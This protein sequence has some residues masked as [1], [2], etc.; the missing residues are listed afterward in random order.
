MMDNL[1]KRTQMI[2]FGVVM[3]VIVSVMFGK[4]IIGEEKPS[5]E[6]RQQKVATTAA[7]SEA[8]LA[9]LPAMKVLFIGNEYISLNDMPDMFS[10][11]ANAAEA[12]DFRVEV[13][14]HAPAGGSLSRAWNDGVARDLIRS[15]KWT[16]VILQEQPLWAV[17]ASSIAST[18]ASVQAFSAEVRA[19]GAQVLLL[20]P[21]SFKLGSKWYKDLQYAQILRNPQH[22]NALIK[23]ETAKLASQIGAS[24]IPAGDYW[25]YALKQNQKLALYAKDGTAPSPAGSFFT[26]LLLYRYF[27][28]GLPQDN[29]FSVKKVNPKI[30]AELKKIASVQ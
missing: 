4:K 24:V 10:Q 22:M 12:P 23:Q 8:R 21:W 11:M 19:V 30:T 5:A 26:S 28:G 2:I 20:Q 13:K 17:D 14:V 9:S 27:T 18:T 15:E 29:T 16:Y 1:S 6:E 7:E 25:Q 3:V